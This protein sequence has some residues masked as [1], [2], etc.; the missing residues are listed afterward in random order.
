MARMARRIDH[1][2]LGL[3]CWL[4]CLLR[5]LLAFLR[6]VLSRLTWQRIAKLFRLVQGADCT[7]QPRMGRKLNTQWAL[8]LSKHNWTVPNWR[9]IAT[10]KRVEPTGATFSYSNQSLTRI[11]MLLVHSRTECAMRTCRLP[12]IS[13]QVLSTLRQ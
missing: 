5:H 2:L 7:F 10:I 3:S 1:L 9:R 13:L 4:S 12:R 6:V 11:R 8:S